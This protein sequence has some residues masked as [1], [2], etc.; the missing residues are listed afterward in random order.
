VPIPG[1]A[2]RWTARLRAW[3]GRSIANQATLGAVTLALAVATVLGGT[4][5]VAVR[6]LVA[7]NIAAGLEGQARLVEQKLLL[8]L[9]LV[10][11]DLADLA[12]NSFVANGLVDSMGRDTYL[13]PF[14]REH[15]LPVRSV[16]AVVL[17]DFR[18]TPIASNLLV[19]ATLV[20]AMRGPREVL[21]TGRSH[22]EVVNG[23]AGVQLLL[24]QPVVF[25]P[26]GQTEGV[27]VLLIDM[28][29]MLAEAKALLGPEA[30][31]GLTVNGM[32]VGAGSAAAPIEGV[33]RWLATADPLG[34]M[35]FGLTV[36]TSLSAQAP[37]RWVAL[38][39]LGIGL[40]TV[41]VVVRAARA[42]ARRL[43]AP[44]EA[45]SAAASR[46]A[47][48]GEMGAA[49]AEGR[50]D[51]VG[52]LTAA[53]T[54][55]VSRLRASHEELE[56]RVRD[57][58]A[59][60]QKREQELQRY[61]ETQAVLLREVNHRVKN[62]LSAIIGVLHLEEGRATSRHEE[63]VSR[64]L[65]EMETRI[66]SLATVHSLLS[67]VDWQPLP[68]GD[69]CQRILRTSL[70]EG[71]GAPPELH[72]DPSPVRVDS[73][74]AHNLALVLNELATNTLKHG[75]P[76]AGPSRVI[77]E[78]GKAGEDVVLTYRDRGPGFP[79]VLLEIQPAG[80][81]TGLQLVRGI[82]E[83]SLGGTLTL[84]NDGGAVTTIRFAAGA[85]PR[86]GRAA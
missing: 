5:F 8:D 68:I 40:A 35:R 21:S 70:G 83:S 38:A 78:I 73:G 77:V 71:G 63:A 37:L 86:E 48:G 4:T 14:L 36:G 66:R 3:S 79:P 60:L 43:A 34:G 50:T 16:V 31:V 80:G 23:P 2:A 44:I 84:A 57:R 69:L 75:R 30:V 10:T 17:C 7:R 45:L 74:Q 76:Q 27:I 24:S 59:E 22:S 51:E 41:V 39:Y 13:L 85:P 33:T 12:E 18:G 49:A 61:A 81:G 28:S 19:P 65:Q 62:N 42:M 54:A 82:V 46:V 72:V 53:F 47:A 67:G 52:A 64:I 11:Q 58:T 26:T 25:P 32:A 29:R 55:M 20:G 6:T 1:F 15:R 56:A 9:K